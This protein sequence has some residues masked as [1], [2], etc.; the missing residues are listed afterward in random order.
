[1]QIQP[2]TILAHGSGQ[3]IGIT[4]MIDV[5]RPKVDEHEGTETRRVHALR[6]VISADR[7]HAEQGRGRVELWDGSTWQVVHAVP[8]TLL[9]ARNSLREP[10]QVGHFEADVREMLRVVWRLLQIPGTPDM[11]WLTG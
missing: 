6:I 5:L 11:S 3:T 2:I 7:S 9:E 1:M 8:G 10:A 4:A